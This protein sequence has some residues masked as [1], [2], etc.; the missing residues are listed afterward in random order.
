M[1]FFSSLATATVL[2]SLGWMQA[3]PAEAQTRSEARGARRAEPARVQRESRFAPRRH[4]AVRHS[5]EQ[6]DT[7]SNATASAA[8]SSEGSIGVGSQGQSLV[9]DNH[10][11]A[12]AST[13]VA[14]AL[15]SS[16]D[17]CM[18]SGSVGAAGVAFGLSLGTTYT[19]ENCKMLK[20][21]RELWNMGYRGAA[22]AR[23][24]MDQHNRQAL[25]ISGVRCPPDKKS[26]QAPLAQ[27]RPESVAFDPASH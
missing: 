2:A 4:E 5:R 6:T 16:N 25:E 13:A 12:S 15:T 9:V 22:M 20:N 27:V 3:Q 21:A 23:L 14:P 1:K 7:R 26:V 18:G 19:D 10:A 8:A 24:C 11:R 17:T